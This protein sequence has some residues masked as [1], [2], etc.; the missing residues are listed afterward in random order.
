[1]D[2]DGSSGDS[3]YGC[4]IKRNGSLGSYTYS[5]ADDWANRPVNNVSWADAARFANWLHNGQPTGSQDMSTT[6]NGTYNL[7]ATQQYYGPNGET[8]DPTSPEWEALVEALQSVARNT[9]CKWAITSEDE[10]YK[11]AYHKNNGVTGDYFE[12]PT[13]SDTAPSIAL[14]DPDPGNNATFKIDSS[15]EYTIGEPYWRTEVGAHENSYSPYGTFDQAGNLREWNESILSITF[16]GIRGGTFDDEYP[17]LHASSRNGRN[18]TYEF[19]DI[20]FRVSQVPEP[21]SISLLVLG[22]F[23]L[24][25]KRR[26]A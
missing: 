22:G 18:P 19:Y 11:A 23:G 5:V 12:Y 10:F 20:G 14:I 2:I 26:K 13:S 7:S 21:T 16:R 3:D 17:S 6:E 25:K 9:N 15:N 1:M 4:N 24:L 8:P